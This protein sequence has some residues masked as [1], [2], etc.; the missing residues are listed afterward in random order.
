MLDAGWI[1]KDNLMAQHPVVCTS[2]GSMERFSNIVSCLFCQA[3]ESSLI[4]VNKSSLLNTKLIIPDLLFPKTASPGQSD[5]CQNRPQMRWTPLWLANSLGAI[6]SLPTFTMIH[7]LLTSDSVSSL[8]ISAD[9]RPK[10][11][12][13]LLPKFRPCRPNYWRGPEPPKLLW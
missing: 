2:A 3:V 7:P 1:L 4:V 10:V 13:L 9:D 6:N 5:N 8:I 12:S 11:L